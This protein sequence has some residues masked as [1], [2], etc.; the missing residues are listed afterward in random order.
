M[1]N[2]LA[3]LYQCLKTLREKCPWDRAQTPLSL[4][5]K[6]LEE[7]YEL[8]DALERE[9]VSLVKEELGDVLLHILFQSLFGEEKKAFSLAEVMQTLH[10]KLIARHPQIFATPHSDL[11]YSEQVKAWEQKKDQESETHADPWRNVP[12]HAP[13][14]LLA[15]KTLKVMARLS[16][17]NQRQQEKRVHACNELELAIHQL[18]SL[19]QKEEENLAEPSR[20]LERAVGLTLLGMAQLAQIHHISAE[21]ALRA[22][23]RSLQQKHRNTHTRADAPDGF[24]EPKPEA[25]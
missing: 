11:T 12:Q 14:L 16:S 22:A 25:Q 18:M 1:D 7:A 13:A 6:L 4:I 20:D 21:G 17:P 19:S 9:N 10:I 23:C 3:V 2:D 8:A 5:P 15:E 24:R